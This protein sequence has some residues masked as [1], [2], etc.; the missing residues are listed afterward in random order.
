VRERLRLSRRPPSD[1]PVGH[2]GDVVLSAEKRRERQRA[3]WRPHGSA[4]WNA[5]VRRWW[6]R[7]PATAPREVSHGCRHN[8]GPGRKVPFER[9]RLVNNNDGGGHNKAMGRVVTNNIGN[10]PGNGGKTWRHIDDD[11]MWAYLCRVAA[12]FSGRD[13]SSGAA[14]AKLMSLRL[15][16]IWGSIYRCGW[17]VG[18]WSVEAFHRPAGAVLASEREAV[19]RCPAGCVSV[20]GIGVLVQNGDEE[21]RSA[22]ISL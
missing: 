7:R 16:K 2:E 22:Y 6:G 14:M 10:E 5:R 13:A 19:G 17:L 20:R 1:H 12:R 18:R 8:L 15:L 11:S 3:H 4:C 9:Q 21:G